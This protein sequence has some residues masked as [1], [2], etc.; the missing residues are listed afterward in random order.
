MAI[1][2]LFFTDHRLWKELMFGPITPYQYRLCGPDPWPLARQTILTQMERVLEAMGRSRPAGAPGPEADGFRVPICPLGI[3]A[4]TASLC[5]LYFARESA[6]RDRLVT[7]I[8]PVRDWGSSLATTM[9]R[10]LL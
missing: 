9:S 1:G 10:R 2:R 3:I 8:S 6:L 5:Y 4:V 7:L